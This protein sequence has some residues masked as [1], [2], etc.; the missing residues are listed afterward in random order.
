VAS[1]ESSLGFLSFVLPRRSWSLAFYGQTLSSLDFP[2]PWSTGGQQTFLSSLVI[3]NVGVS[4]AV[5][6]SEAVDIGFG[7][8]WFAGTST[9]GIFDQPSSSAILDEDVQTAFGGTVGVLWKLDDAWSIGTAARTGADFSFSTANRAVFPDIV[10]TG[11]RWKSSGGHATMAAEVEFLDGLESRVRPHLGA[12]WVFLDVTPLI[13]IR[14][15][16]WHDPKGGAATTDSGSGTTVDDDV[17]HASVGLGFAW[18]KF[19]LDVA[20]DLSER[21]TITSIS[22]IYTFGP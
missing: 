9:E 11:A 18:R 15:G 1:N 8:T 2:R 5:E 17:L 16:L 10:S 21:T 13:G 20:A 19:Q 3:A 6:L 14:T 4:A 7:L 22:G 12:E